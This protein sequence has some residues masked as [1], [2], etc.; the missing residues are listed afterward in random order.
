MKMKLTEF[1]RSFRKAR[2]AADRG[3]SIIV[4]GEN[5]DYM[6]ERR[7]ATS[8]HPFVGLEDVFG[9]VTLP[10]G[11][12]SLREKPAVASPR[13]TVIVDARPLEAAIDRGDIDHA[14]AV[15]AF[16]T[17]PGRFITCEATI[18]EAQRSPPA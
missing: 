3:D 6:F 12:R 4:R 10:R 13:K 17:V 11:K 5:G 2:E 18:A 9:A 7:A 8:D 16:R 15:D 1:L 14:R